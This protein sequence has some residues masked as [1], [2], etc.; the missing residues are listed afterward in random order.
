MYFVPNT[1]MNIRIIENITS[2]DKWNKDIIKKI[3]IH[4]SKT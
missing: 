3:V 2:L 4:L 1:T